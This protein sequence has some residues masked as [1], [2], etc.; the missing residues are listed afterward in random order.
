MARMN[1]IGKG[2]TTI[3]TE[4]GKTTVRY[5]ATDVVTFDK[6][7]IILNS[8]GWYT[9]STKDRLNQTAAQ[10]ALG[11]HV[12]QEANEWHVSYKGESVDFF[13]GMVLDR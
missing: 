8:G 13:D 3:K 12:Y 1:R 6:R 11:F 7:R 5:H 2:N 10:F 9:K 4:N